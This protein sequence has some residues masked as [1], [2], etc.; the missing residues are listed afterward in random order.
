M[1]FNKKYK[2]TG[3]LFEGTFKSVHLSEDTQLKYLFSYIHLNP[4]KL[5]DPKWRDMGIKDYKKALSFLDTYSWSSYHD[6][7]ERSRPE[8]K[9]ISKKDFPDYFENQRMFNE[10]IL[11]WLRFDPLSFP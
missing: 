9:I 11:E 2:R 1:Y 7:R 5:I 8:D 6:Y 10:E 3:K 4:V